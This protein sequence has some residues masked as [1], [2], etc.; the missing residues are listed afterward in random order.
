MTLPP[1][2]EF[3]PGILQLSNRLPRLE[4]PFDDWE[5]FKGFDLI[6]SELI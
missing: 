1:T 5:C 6:V 2:L 3:P 4:S